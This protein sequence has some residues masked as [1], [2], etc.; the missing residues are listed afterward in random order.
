MKSLLIISPHFPPV[1]AADM[2]RVR[3][4]LPY[5]QGLGW[6]PVVV[7]VDPGHVETGQDALLL[8]SLPE[9]VEVIRIKALST[10][11]TRK[12]GLGSL[13]LRSLWYYQE[14]VAKLLKKRHFDL[15]YFSTTM[16]PVPMLGN[17]WKRR[18]GIP[19][20]IDMQDPWHSDY[21]INKPKSE[22]P[23]K[24]WFSYN[25]NK[26]T[27]PIAMKRADGI[28]AVSEAYNQ[29]LQERYGNITPEKCMALT[30]GAFEKDFE[31][32]QKAAVPNR[33]FDAQDGLFHIPY[34]GR[35][36]HDMRFALSCIFEALKIGLEKQPALFERVRLYYIGTSYAADGKGKKTVWPL[37]NEMGVGHLVVESTDRIPFYEA[38]RLL[39]D[40][41]M[42]LVPGSDDPK[43]TASKLYNYIL[44]KKRLAAVFHRQ[45]SVLEILR[46]TKAGVPIGFD[47][48]SDVSD[49]AQRLFEKWSGL[50]GSGNAPVATDWDAFAPFMAQEMTKKQVIFFEKVLSR[51][52]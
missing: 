32:L 18:F 38:L 27:E 16:F 36:G 41:H 17:I 31:V 37:A 23:P 5:F 14:E 46:N 9:D 12:I 39:K 15:I 47:G 40:A 19:Y 21:Y 52:M 6:Q 2:H 20:V 45:S 22:R 10:K 49:I 29:T 50:L 3:Q 26:Y 7:A 13:A 43:Y 35:A 4:S 42:L 1:N 51:Q 48:T 33:F 8:K 11:Y 34:I 25:L 44:A 28:I 24:Y 30:F